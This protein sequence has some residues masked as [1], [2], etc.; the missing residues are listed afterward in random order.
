[1][2]KYVFILI[3]FSLFIIG[4]IIKENRAIN[5]QK[6]RNYKGELVEI[7]RDINDRDTY[8]YRIKTQQGNILQDVLFYRE[9]FNYVEVGD[10]IIKIEGEPFITVK[11]KSSSYNASA[12]FPCE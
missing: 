2:K 4:T 3:G 8:K 11:K 12:V 7:F 1:M 9:S 10:S 5:K 6:E